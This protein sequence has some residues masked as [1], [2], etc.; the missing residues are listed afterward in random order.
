MYPFYVMALLFLFLA[1][2]AL[3]DTSLV[4][5]AAF[6]AF[7]G[8]RWTLVHI[9]T[10]GVL[11]EVVFGLTPGLVAALA[12]R[13]RPTVS[14]NTWIVLNA[15]LITLLAGIPLIHNVLITTGGTLV[16]T[17]VLM[18]LWALV[19]PGAGGETG[20]VM[21]RQDQARGSAVGTRHLAPAGSLR[22]VPAGCR[23]RAGRRRRFQHRHRD[24]RQ[25]R[26]NPHL[27]LDL[28]VRLRPDPLSL[29]ARLPTPMARPTGGH[30][31]QPDCRQH[32]WRPVL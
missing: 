12:R 4:N 21:G 11:T 24:S 17:A 16:F 10:L 26:A 29:C 28:A 30:L 6:S 8:L 13:P 27:R 3:L 22:L 23:G 9:M 32:R 25:R 20:Q 31:V 18:L 14:W 7:P 15:G 5:L 2:L 1:A 19:A